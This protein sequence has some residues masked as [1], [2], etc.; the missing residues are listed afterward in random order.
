MSDTYRDQLT[1]LGARVD[2][3]L[4]LQATQIG[5]LQAQLADATA[6]RDRWKAAADAGLIKI[7]TLTGRIADLERQLAASL[8]W[9]PDKLGFIARPTGPDYVRIEDLGVGSDLRKAAVHP[10]AHGKVVTLPVGQFTLDDFAQGDGKFMHGLMVSG[11]AKTRCRGIVGSGADTVISMVPNSS[12][13]TAATGA[14]GTENTTQFPQNIILF[15]GVDGVEF[16]N[17][18]L[19]GTPQPH[20]HHG[21]RST[22]RT[23]VHHLR[24][25]GA[26]QGGYNMPPA[27][28]YSC[29]VGGVGSVIEDSEFD[30]R[31]APGEKPV[32]S[33]VVATLAATNAVIRR[34]HMH[35][36]LSGFGIVQWEG[37]GLTTE[38]VWVTRPGTG[39]SGYNGAHTNHEKGA[40][41]IKHV[42]PRITLDGY[43][44]PTDGKTRRNSSK[45]PHFI[46]LRPD[47]VDDYADVQIIDPVY[48][49]WGGI[50]GGFAIMCD[51]VAA[52]SPM[53]RVIIDG[54]TLTGVI[55]PRWWVDGPTPFDPTTQ[56]WVAANSGDGSVWG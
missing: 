17:L 48:D 14:Q 3:D 15:Y 31:R 54:K 22:G 49:S 6:E 7:D 44:G 43:W 13:F 10:G 40:G 36:L 12:H 5:G 53:P 42:R 20:Y 1:E 51:D 28:T 35:D 19:A 38:D 27:E 34:C 4:A 33:S 56:Y 55:R 29:A 46:F 8:A 2:A 52:K 26:A 32:S 18:T 41:P 47:L 39:V 24:T 25:L 21:F 23:H 30:G 50:K 37:Q 16:G 9:T 45:F 11:T